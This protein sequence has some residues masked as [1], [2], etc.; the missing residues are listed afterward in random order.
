MKKIRMKLFRAP[1]LKRF[2][3]RTLFG[4]SLLI[5][6]VPVFLIQVLTT[7]AFFDRHWDRMTSRLAYAVAGL[8]GAWAW[9]ADR[10][11]WAL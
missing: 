1:G 7:Y 5:L 3:P 11:G 8:A 9:R 10:L 6:V 4:R 2:L